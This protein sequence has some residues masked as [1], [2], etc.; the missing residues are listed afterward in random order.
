MN[1]LSANEYKGTDFFTSLI[2]IKHMIIYSR[3]L[4][5]FAE[6]P[7]WW[8]HNTWGGVI[9]PRVSRQPIGGIPRPII[10]GDGAD[11][12]AAL[13]S[14]L[15]GSVVSDGQLD[16]AWKLGFQG[17]GSAGA[18]RT[19]AGPETQRAPPWTLGADSFSL[20]SS[21]SLSVCIFTS[22][23]LAFL[24]FFLARRKLYLLNLDRT[25]FFS[26]AKKC[27]SKLTHK[28]GVQ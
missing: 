24:F 9:G 15:A 14:W 10:S 26:R 12:E 25:V 21:R 6:P 7:H 8:T 17:V 3:A 27:A 19:R 18:V 28:A 1:K 11:V 4:C 16:G 23:S 5:R 2:E 22:Q 13:A 20:N